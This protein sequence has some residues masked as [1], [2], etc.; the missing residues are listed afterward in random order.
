M[1]DVYAEWGRFCLRYRQV[2]ENPKF[3]SA[4]VDLPQ[5]DGAAEFRVA[6]NFSGGKQM[7]G[8]LFFVPYY[9]VDPLGITLHHNKMIASLREGYC[10]LV[11]LS[12]DAEWAQIVWP[13]SMVELNN[14]IANSTGSP[15]LLEAWVMG[16]SRE[17][18]KLLIV[19]LVQNNACYGYLLGSPG[20]A[21]FSEVRVI[22]ILF[23]RVEEFALDVRVL[24]ELELSVKHIEELIRYSR[25]LQPSSGDAQ[26]DQRL[27]NALDELARA[28]EKGAS[29][30]R[31]TWPR[32]LR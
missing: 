10:L 31:P 20:N 15:Q 22:P 2:T 5:F 18:N 21:G 11:P 29:R 28:L 8:T 30:S 14:F 25:L 26:E 27:C 32:V 12:V 1:K 17:F 7:I 6:A 13:K 4:R 19:V 3:A 23:D 9:E 16:R 24:I